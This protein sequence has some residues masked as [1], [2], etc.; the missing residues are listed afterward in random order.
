[1]VNLLKQTPEKEAVVALYQTGDTLSIR[2]NRPYY[3]TT[4][5]AQGNFRL[6]NVKEGSY[7]MYA[8]VDKNNNSYYDSEEERIAYLPEPIMI[9]PT[10]DTVKLQTIRI[11]TKK[12]ILL[13]RERFTDR[14]VANYNEGI[15]AFNAISVTG[16]DT[17]MSR[18]ATDGKYA[19]LF[20]TQNFSGGK[21]IL[22]AIDSAGN[23]GVDTLEIAFEGKISTRIKGAQ[24]KVINTKNSGGFAVGQPVVIELQTPVRIQGTTPISL[25]ADSTVIHTLT[26]PE[27]IS[28]DRTNTEIRFSLPSIPNKVKQVVIVLDTA[29]VVPLEGAPL[30]IPQLQLS[31]SEEKGT[32]VISGRINTSYTSYIVQLLNSEFKVVEQQQGKNTY[33]F[34]SVTPGTYQIRVLIDANNNGKWDK[35]DPE[36]KRLPEPVYIHPKALEVR[37]NWEIEKENLE[38]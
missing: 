7:R 12:P 18:I 22:A 5:D 11:D 34:N 29:A 23:I 20:K 4:T 3:L 14:F 10:T 32:G 37:A 27:Q 8:L 24:V 33:R 30:S 36:F 13:A 35:G 26:Y 21:A 38:F 9:T 25:M 1:M 19:E 2:K 15:Q 28:L 31:I 16:K 17:I 6:D